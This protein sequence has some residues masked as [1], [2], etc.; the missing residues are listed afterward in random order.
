MLGGADPLVCAG[1]PRPALPSRNQVLATIDKP[2]GGP[3]GPEGTPPR[4]SAPAKKAGVRSCGLGR[5]QW[6]TSFSPPA[7]AFGFLSRDG[8]KAA[9]RGQAAFRSSG[10]L[11]KSRELALVNQP[12]FSNGLRAGRSGRRTHSFARTGNYQASDGHRLIPQRSFCPLVGI[13]GNI[14][15]ILFQRLHRAALISGNNSW[16]WVRK[17]QPEQS[18]TLDI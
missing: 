7:A 3:T 5:S 14:G 13:C 12:M 2:A 8:L 4:A 6:R 18:R 1:R 11:P 17:L 10:G 15:R 9:R 16:S